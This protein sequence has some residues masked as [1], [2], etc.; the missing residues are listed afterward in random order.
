MVIVE[1]FQS[2]R[3]EVDQGIFY[4]NFYATNYLLNCLAV[5]LQRDIQY[6][7]RLNVAHFPLHVELKFS[8]LQLQ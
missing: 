7:E 5:N 3:Y 6:F 8:H 4:Y 2:R 1:E